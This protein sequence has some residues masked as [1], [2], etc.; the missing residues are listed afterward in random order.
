M[1]RLSTLGVAIAASCFSTLSAADDAVK[2]MVKSIEPKVIEWRHHIHQNP[3]LSNREFKTAALVAKHLRGLGIEVE[4]K[5]AYTGVVGVLDSGKPGPVVALRADMDALPVKENSGVD[6]ASTAMGE[7]NGEQVPVSHACGHD[8]HVAMLMGAAELLASNKD[9]F[10]GK[11]VFLFQPA[12]EGAPKGE[13]GGAEM[14]VAEGALSKHGVESVFGIHISSGDEEGAIGY[15]TK[16]IMAGVDDFK[17]TVKGK[18]VHGAY[19]WA[20]I[21][22]VVTSAQLI[23]QIQTIVS[24]EAMLIEAGAVVTVGAIHGGVRSNIIPNEVEMLGTIR[25]FDKDMRAKVFEGMHRR[26]NGIAEA[27]GTEIKLE[28]PYS[29]SYP[30]TYNNPALTK[31]VLPIMER[32]AGKDMVFERRAVTGAEDFSFF[33]Q[34]VPGVY[35]FLGGR[36]PKIPADQAPAHHTPEFAV[37]DGAMKTGVE[38]FYR[39]VTEYPVG[40]NK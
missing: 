15:R 31:A 30:V 28:L 16:G 12:E 33:Q 26:V 17:I 35:V 21:D 36:D 38:L 40:Y 3:E 14:M 6:F 24:R 25:T 2:S 7:Y 5:V 8:T 18:Q 32:A 27:T 1:N 4:E 37:Q 10:T 34:E 19:P 11:V 29:A 39:W 23:N 13:G 9:S 20:G 22:P